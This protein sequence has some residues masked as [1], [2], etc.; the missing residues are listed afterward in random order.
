MSYK[1]SGQAGAEL[2]EHFSPQKTVLFLVNSLA[3]PSES[4]CRVPSA[5]GTME[6]LEIWGF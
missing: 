5:T 6:Q 1:A 3:L 4:H 2:L